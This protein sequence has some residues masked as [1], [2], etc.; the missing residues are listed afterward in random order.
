VIISGTVERW[1]PLPDSLDLVRAPVKAVAAAVLAEVTRF[2]AG[3]QLSSA[4]V[5]FSSLDQL[6]GSV[7]VY[8]TEPTVYFVLP[9]RSDWSVLWNNSYAC[10]GDDSLCWCLTKNHGFTTMHW[11]SSDED[12]VFQAGSSFTCRRPAGSGLRERWVYCCK[13][14]ESWDFHAVGVPLPEEN[15]QAYATGRTRDRLNEQGML[16][17]LERLGARPWQDDFYMPGEAL[18]IERLTYPNTTHHKRFSEFACKRVER[19][20]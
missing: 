13:N 7:A 18:R 4:W 20:G 11:R 14:D 12:V 6:F 10:D 15:L 16:E 9:T 1:W 8:T 3:G 5:P 19:H 2:A 17:L